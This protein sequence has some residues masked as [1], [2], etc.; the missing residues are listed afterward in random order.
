MNLLGERV[1]DPDQSNAAAQIFASLGDQIIG[2]IARTD[3]FNRDIGDDIAGISSVWEWFGPWPTLIGDI[4]HI[5]S[6]TSRPVFRQRY[7]KKKSYPTFPEVLC[8]KIDCYCSIET[9]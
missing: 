4:G 3:Y 7:S 1:D 2:R 9:V 6:P 5:R 8:E